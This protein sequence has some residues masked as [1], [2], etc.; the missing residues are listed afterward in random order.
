M[1]TILSYLYTPRTQYSAASRTA[2][3]AP[4]RVGELLSNAGLFQE[5]PAR[6]ADEVSEVS[7]AS[8]RQ[9]LS[10]S[11]GQEKRRPKQ[12]KRV[13]GA[14]LVRSSLKKGALLEGPLTFVCIVLRRGGWQGRVAECCRGVS[15]GHEL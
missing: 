3:P 10:R 14:P 2:E 15:T 1:G 6:L 12:Q 9:S 8:T 4:L 5:A 13:L 7:T 11:V